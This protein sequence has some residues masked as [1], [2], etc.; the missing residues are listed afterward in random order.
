MKKVGPT[1]NV[2]E[3]TPIQLERWRTN[4]TPDIYILCRE[5]P[6]CSLIN[7]GEPLH[8]FLGMCLLQKFPEV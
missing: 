1:T 3:P 8:S 6:V 2:F 7:L 4:C 5:F